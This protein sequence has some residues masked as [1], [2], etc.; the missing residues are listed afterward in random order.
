MSSQSPAPL[1]RRS[2][3]AAR[4]RDDLST[5][6]HRQL[7]GYVAFLFSWIL[8][9]IA[10]WRSTRELPGLE[11]LGSVSAY[12]Y[13]G[14]VAAFVG[15]LVALAA[16]LFTY[17]GYGKEAEQRPDLVAAWIAGIAALL[18]AFFPTTAPLVS[19]KPSW[20]EPW[21]R[22]TH[23]LGAVV[24]FGTLIFFSVVLFPR[25]QGI[26]ERFGGKWWRNRIYYLCGGLMV[27]CMAWAAIAGFYDKTIFWP[28]TVALMAFGVSWLTKGR[29]D[30]TL[31][32]AV[33]HPRQL[34]SEVRKAI[35]G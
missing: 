5:H 3:F 24:L 18:V 11:I 7:I 12:Y 29:A 17:R 25:S 14:A 26:P 1:V 31:T 22:V 13:T 9:L 16:F 30:W 2:L 6:L 4:E 8:L 27:A 33:R 32:T 35:R 10:W 34:Y 23:Y 15:G 20:W 28:E 19:L 21:M